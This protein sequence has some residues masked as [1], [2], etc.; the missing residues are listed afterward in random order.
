MRWRTTVL[1]LFSRNLLRQPVVQAKGSNFRSSGNASLAF[2]ITRTVSFNNK[3]H[4]S[5]CCTTSLILLK[6]S[7]C[8]ANSF[9][10]SWKHSN[11][12]FDFLSIWNPINEP[13]RTGTT[14]ACKAKEQRDDLQQLFVCWVYPVQQQL[15]RRSY[16]NISGTGGTD[17]REALNLVAPTPPD[18]SLRVHSEW[19]S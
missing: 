16:L 19:L 14:N 10:L 5:T 4:F 9:C 15:Q 6:F 7:A 17:N 11:T 2:C 1:E 3:L 18:L 13:F 8:L 12:R